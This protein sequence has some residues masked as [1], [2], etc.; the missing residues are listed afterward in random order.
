MFKIIPDIPFYYKYLE[1][2]DAML[3]GKPWLYQEILLLSHTLPS[4][5]CQ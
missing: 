2:P 1:G 3:F 4:E 5:I